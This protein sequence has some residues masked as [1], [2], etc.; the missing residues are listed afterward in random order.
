MKTY[1]RLIA[2]FVIALGLILLW[3]PK[4]AS[5]QTLIRLDSEYFGTAESK[6]SPFGNEV[7]TWVPALAGGTQIWSKTLI[8]PAGYNTAYVTISGQGNDSLGLALQL[9]CLVDNY[10][11]APD[12]GAAYPPP[13]LEVLPNG[14][15]DGAPPG[16]I[17]VLKHFNYETDYWVPGYDSTSGGDN[18]LLLEEE[19]YSGNGDM[20]DNNISHTWC[21]NVR[22]GTHTF[23][24]KMGNSCFEYLTPD[25]YAYLP[26][27]FNLVAMS[28]INFYIDASAS[29]TGQ[30]TAASGFR[31]PPPIEAP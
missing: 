19:F 7:Y 27:E 20:H 13:D 10:S 24:I 21:V 4:P 25:C 16:W 30:C 28:N 26:V 22:P 23:S 15:A 5:A 3:M 1:T 17:T 8:V 11:C 14:T 9:Q 29:S 12:F 6:G 2:G 18:E 31:P